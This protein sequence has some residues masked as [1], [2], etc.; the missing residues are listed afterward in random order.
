MAGRPVTKGN[1]HPSSA[2]LRAH[3]RAGW[4]TPCPACKAY[5]RERNHEQ[6]LKRKKPTTKRPRP[7]LDGGRGLP[8]PLTRGATGHVRT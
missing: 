7:P 8:E 4:P 1:E 3:Q 6:Y 2:A 5:E